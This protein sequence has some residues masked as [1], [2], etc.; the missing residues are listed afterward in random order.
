MSD[1]T[2]ILRSL[3]ARRFST[4]VTVASVALA[5]ALLMALLMLR[6]SGQAAFSRGS[7][8]AHLIVSQDNSPLVA[9][10]NGVFYAN[11]PRNPISQ[12]KFAEIKN[13]FPWAWAIPTQL[14]DSY[15]GFPVVATT[16][17]YLSDFEPVEGEPW[18]LAKGRFF[19]AP[20][21]LVIGSEVARA[22]GL[23]LGDAIPLT[24][25]F[26]SSQETGHVHDAH[27]FEVVGILE[28]TASSH[29]RAMFTDLVGSWVLHAEDRLEREGDEDDSGH[30]HD[31]DH[32]HHHAHVEIEDLTDEDRLITG[33][34][35][36]VPTRG[37][38][39]SAVLPQAFDLLRRDTSITVA[40][41][42]NQ[43]QR[44]FAIVGSVD[45]LFIAMAIVVLA[46]SGVGILLALWNSMEQRRRQIA[47]LRVLGC[48][49]ARVFGLIVT[50]SVLI[51]LLGAII[52][53]GLSFAAAAMAARE[54]R[55]RLGL[56]LDPQ[57]GIEL[58]ILI[59]AGT[60]LLAVVAGLAPALRAYNTPV[61]RSLRPLV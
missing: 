36:R 49:R 17:E 2:I 41:P 45:R 32:G 55:D 18:L 21:E 3:L 10:L 50:E 53:V 19:D 48:S 46:S 1:L 31:H 15:K 39:A 52:G 51:G 42:A 23:Q 9:V 43:I 57:L 29:D 47:I 40:S 4:V 16:T 35:L 13:A 61:A 24:H 30:D 20:F 59:L 12:A 34:L 22:T 28:P 58:I 14:G 27:T 8:N 38:S 26:A 54:I 56:V 7:G 33:I 37:G 6:D 5:V 11:P 60:V 44:L 25:G